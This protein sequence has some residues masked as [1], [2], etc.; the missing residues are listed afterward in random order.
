MIHK[1]LLFLVSL[2]ISHFSN[3]RPIKKRRETERTFRCIKRTFSSSKN[4]LNL[5]CLTMKSSRAQNRKKKKQI[6]LKQKIFKSFFFQK[7]IID[8]YS[9]LL[10]SQNQTFLL[11]LYASNNTRRRITKIIDR[12]IIVC[13]FQKCKNFCNLMS[14]FLI[15][16]SKESP[17]QKYCPAHDKGLSAGI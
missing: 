6:K 3:H 12:F 7:E 17:G 14:E 15:Y 13:C 9:G 8:S 2:V 4:I 11:L 1:R 10:F 5:K 16:E